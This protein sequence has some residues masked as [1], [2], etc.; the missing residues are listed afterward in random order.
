M[1]LL[2]LFS[3]VGAIF[4]F[5]LPCSVDVVD[6]TLG[7][8]SGKGEATSIL[9]YSLSMAPILSGMFV[10]FF[11]FFRCFHLCVSDFKVFLILIVIFFGCRHCLYLFF[12]MEVVGVW[13]FPP[14]ITTNV[15]C[16]KIVFSFLE[17][18]SSS[19]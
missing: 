13:L 2:L 18:E 16:E 9:V 11:L 17:S 4:Y 5:F 14:S 7:G 10:H 12:T 15:V 1:A 6:D 3:D 19:L 8:V